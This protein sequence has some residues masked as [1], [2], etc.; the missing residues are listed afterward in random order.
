MCLFTI[1]LDIDEEYKKLRD[2][3]TEIRELKKQIE[4]DS[5]HRP[6]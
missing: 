2:V 3:A 6:L 5:I 1:D 4:D